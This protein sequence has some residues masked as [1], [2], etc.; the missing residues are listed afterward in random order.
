[1]ESTALTYEDIFAFWGTQRAYSAHFD[2]VRRTSQVMLDD[3]PDLMMQFGRDRLLVEE[4]PTIVRINCQFCPEHVFR[5][6]VCYLRVANQATN[7]NG[8]FVPQAHDVLTTILNKAKADLDPDTPK[9]IALLQYLFDFPKSDVLPVIELTPCFERIRVGCLVIARK[10]VEWEQLRY[11][12]VK[13]AV[14]SFGW[15]PHPD[16]EDS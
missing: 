16:D 4:A 9:Q 7:P 5:K 8:A 11:S 15:Q 2:Y 14:K 13:A 12:H 1:M 6:A 3:N 10:F